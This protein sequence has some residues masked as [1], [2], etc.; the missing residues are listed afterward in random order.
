[1]QLSFRFGTF[2]RCGKAFLEYL[3]QLTYPWRRLGRLR[4]PLCRHAIVGFRKENIGINDI[5]ILT[6]ASATAIA[7]LL[8]EDCLSSRLGVGAEPSVG[9]LLDMVF[10][11]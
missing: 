4:L 10:V 6:R 1:M 5:R 11:Y 7:L 8:G 3:G 9:A 2:V